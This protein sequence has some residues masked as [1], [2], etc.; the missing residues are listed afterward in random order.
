[1]VAAA[2][3]HRQPE[4]IF[5]RSQDKCWVISV[6]VRH[7][8]QG[9]RRNLA[10]LATSNGFTHGFV[11]RNN[12]SEVELVLVKHG[13]PQEHFASQL[14]KVYDRLISDY[15]VTREDCQRAEEN[16]T[17][18]PFLT[19]PFCIIKYS[20]NDDTLSDENFDLLSFEDDIEIRSFGSLPFNF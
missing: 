17:M 3:S 19:Q 8:Q 12:A 18:T 11:K 16:T 10:H 1:M 20:E 7:S 5:P 14:E 6:I 2:S 15:S 13:V 9:V 4:D